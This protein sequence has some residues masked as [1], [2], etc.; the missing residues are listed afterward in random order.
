MENWK[1][2]LIEYKWNLR[3]KGIN[4]TYLHGDN[5]TYTFYKLDNGDYIIYKPKSLLYIPITIHPNNTPNL[6]NQFIV[7]HFLESISNVSKERVLSRSLMSYADAG[8][9]II[10]IKEYQLSILEMFLSEWMKLPEWT[11]DAMKENK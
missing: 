8:R 4:Y 1:T 9:D 6:P 3:V 11:G 10:A 7:S 2:L 5:R